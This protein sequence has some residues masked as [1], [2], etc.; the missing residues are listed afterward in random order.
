MK[1]YK[2]IKTEEFLDR[3]N[4]V[5]VQYHNAIN[6]GIER[7]SKNPFL[8]ESRLK[9]SFLLKHEVSSY[10]I[11]YHVNGN[12]LE[13]WTIDLMPRKEDYNNLKELEKK[14][15]GKYPSAFRKKVKQ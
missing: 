8:R 12:V 5:P 15:K 4:K 1:I 14:I 10:R 2:I 11:I 7:L 13:I 6:K 9:D 3:L